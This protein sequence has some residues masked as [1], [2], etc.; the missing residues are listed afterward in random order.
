MFKKIGFSGLVLG[1]LTLSVPGMAASEEVFSPTGTGL[2][3]CEGKSAT[4]PKRNQVEFAVQVFTLDFVFDQNGNPISTEKDY[5]QTIWF[6]ND[7]YA[8]SQALQRCNQIIDSYS[9]EPGET[10]TSYGRGGVR[11]VSRDYDLKSTR[12]WVKSFSPGLFPWSD[13]PF[14]QCLKKIVD[15]TASS[16]SARQKN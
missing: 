1:L 16:L 12:G 10:H 5:V 7:T 6:G 14:Q 3:R 13:S 4:H 8:G 9:C 11:A 2:I 15:L